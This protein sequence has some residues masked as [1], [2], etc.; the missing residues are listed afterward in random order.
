MALVANK[1]VLE[2]YWKGA[3]TSSDL[4][5]HQQEKRSPDFPKPSFKTAH[6]R[7]AFSNRESVWIHVMF[8]VTTFYLSLTDIHTAKR[9]K[10]ISREGIW[11]FGQKLG[12]APPPLVVNVVWRSGHVIDVRL[13]NGLKLWGSPSD[14]R[15][16]D[17]GR[18]GGL[19]AFGESPAPSRIVAE[20]LSHAHDRRRRRDRATAGVGE[21]SRRQNIPTQ[22]F[23]P[24]NV[25][26]WSVE[27]GNRGI[28]DLTG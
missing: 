19:T 5:R 26:R 3:A 27:Q 23:L 17:L 22:F 13:D 25:R 12:V 28:D 11:A 16:H 20:G 18:V 1:G 21:L 9:A 8:T 15:A 6:F 24:V 14:S 7:R 4:S 10:T 2:K